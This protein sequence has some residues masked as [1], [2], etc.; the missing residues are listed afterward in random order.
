MYKIL[1]STEVRLK[2]EPLSTFDKLKDN[3]LIRNLTR[4]SLESKQL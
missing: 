1:K 3:K 4:L 2:A